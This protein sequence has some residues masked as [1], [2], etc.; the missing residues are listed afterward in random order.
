MNSSRVFPARIRAAIA[1]SIAFHL[2]ALALLATLPRG[3]V[4]PTNSL[5][6]RAPV[7]A[8]TTVRRRPRQPAPA[9]LPVVRVTRPET[10]AVASPAPLR[11]VR[12]IVRQREPAAPA[13]VK[14]ARRAPRVAH[15]QAAPVHAKI[16]AAGIALLAP[17]TPEAATPT[18]TPTPAPAR[19]AVSPTA[20]ATAAAPNS[21]GGLFSQNYPPALPATS[22]LDTIRTRLGGHGRIRIDVDETGHATAV[23]FSDAGDAAA[24]DD[25][26]AQLLAL[27]YVP[28]DC[29][30]LHCDGTLEIS[31]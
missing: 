28:A 18:P 16:A 19:P 12:A 15:P 31:Y 23:H 20:A 17:P 26:R 30:G 5:I 13:A 6:D 29:S 14:I 11:A 2:C 27:S 25:I 22:I 7:F 4:E 1:L 21:F 24:A 9:K 10:V 3:A 8:I